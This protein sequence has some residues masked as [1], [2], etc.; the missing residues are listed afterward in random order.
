MD[1]WKWQQTLSVR[2]TDSVTGRAV[3]HG[4]K[5]V[6]R[7]AGTEPPRWKVQFDDG[8]TRDDIRLDDPAAPVSFD[9]IAYGSTVE[10]RF[11]GGGRRGRL[12]QLVMGSEV[13]GDRWGIRFEDG[14]W[15]EDVKLG[16][17]DVRYVYGRRGKLVEG[18]V[19]GEKRWRGERAGDGVSEGSRKK[20]GTEGKG[21][22][23][24]GEQQEG[25]GG[26]ATACFECKMCGKSF[27]TA[28]SLAT[29]MRTHSGERPHVCE[30]CGKAFSQSGNL[31]RHMRTHSGERPHGCEMCGKAFSTSSNLA[32]HMRSHSGEKPYVCERCGE[33]FS[34]S[35]NLARHM[36][37]FAW[38]ATCGVNPESLREILTNLTE[39]ADL[40]RIFRENPGESDEEM[41]LMELGLTSQNVFGFTN[42]TQSWSGCALH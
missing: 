6:E 8:K 5:L 24:D 18:A 35:G 40:E 31:Y 20:V 14:G 9:S 1:G 7:V 42:S 38:P 36:R 30:T 32:R 29:H 25:R 4:G 26:R 39:D 15:A 17:P 27:S 41:S 28:G 12:V 21:G 34:R 33:A 2:S 13:G 22:P 11:D 19:L 23:R 16:D 10:V 3:W 37:T